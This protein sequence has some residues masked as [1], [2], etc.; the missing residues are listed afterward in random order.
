MEVVGEVL[1]D[2][3]GDAR[4]ARVLNSDRFPYFESGGGDGGGCWSWPKER[5]KEAPM[6]NTV[7]ALCRKM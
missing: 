6:H 4:F 3:G 2:G 7:G 1:G 5:D